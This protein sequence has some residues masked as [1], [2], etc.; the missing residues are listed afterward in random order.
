MERFKA[1]FQMKTNLQDAWSEDIHYKV[2]Q[3][4]KN[5][6]KIGYLRHQPTHTHLR[7]LWFTQGH[8][9]WRWHAWFDRCYQPIASDTAERGCSCL[10]ILAVES[11]IGAAPCTVWAEEAATWSTPAV[12][13]R[14]TTSGRRRATRHAGW[15]WS[16]KRDH[17]TSRFWF[18]MWTLQMYYSIWNWDKERGR[19]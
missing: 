18:E 17:N 14:R 16:S 4:S 15:A 3:R 2:M 9:R 6:H 13:F 1:Y 12:I 11:K 8:T 19:E 10:H 5:R 7:L